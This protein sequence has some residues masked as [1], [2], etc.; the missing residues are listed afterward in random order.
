MSGRKDK[1]HSHDARRLIRKR[2]IWKNFFSTR[3]IQ[4]YFLCKE[5]EQLV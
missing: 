4:H 1:G 2:E 3:D 5:E